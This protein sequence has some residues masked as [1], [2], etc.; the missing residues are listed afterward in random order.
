MEQRYDVVV[1]GAG[2]AAICAAIA[3]HE[4]GATVA[5]LEKATK[6]ERGGNSRFSGALFRFSYAGMDEVLEVA[7]DLDPAIIDVGTYSTADYERDVM[8]T[9]GDRADRALSARVI[10]E[11]LDT[12]KW[13]TGL[14]VAWD[15][16]QSPWTKSDKRF[17]AAPGAVLQVRGKGVGLTDYLFAAAETRGIPIFYEAPAT[18]LSRN[19]DGRVDGVGVRL[20]DGERTLGAGAVVLASGGFEASADLRRRYLGPGWEH[21]RVRGS[22]HNSGETME[23]ALASGAVLD[24]DMAGA[25]ATPIDATAPPF[26]DLSLTDRTNRLSYP[27]GICVDA[28]GERFFDEGEDLAMYTYAKTGRRL[29]SLPGRR[30]YQLFDQKALSLLEGRYETGSPLEADTV[31]GLAQGLEVPPARLAATV[32]EFNRAAAAIEQPFFSTRRDGRQ[33]SGIEPVKS[34]WAVP[35]DE[36]AFVAYPIVCGITF[37]YGGIAIDDQ[38]RVLDEGRQPIPG[39]FASGE[40]TGGLFH[41]N[42]PA[43]AGLMFGAVFGR[44]AGVEAAALA[45]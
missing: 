5:V 37:T 34:N 44:A 20:P 25:H 4:A 22:R 13:L 2:N 24:G 12:V 27:F 26:G 40:I 18:A 35:L 39:L 10:G 31:E 15:P 42:Y 19:G 9:T 33:T 28:H 17:K 43:G 11:S 8:R 6:E 30:A 38:A 36:P 3:A 23:M 41:G 21:A 32:A 45:T 14:G 29:L 16:R 1:V 7:P